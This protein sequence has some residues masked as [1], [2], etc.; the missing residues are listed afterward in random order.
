MKRRIT[1]RLLVFFLK[2][3]LAAGVLFWLVW[4]RRL[5]LAS[6]RVFL[7][8]A[9]P[10]VLAPTGALAVLLGQLL[11]AVRLRMLLK[12]QGLTVSYRR[13]AGLTLIGSLLGV[14]LPGLIG[15]DAVKSLYL[16]ADAPYSRS[17][18][19]AAVMIDRVIGLYSLLL[20]GSLTAGGVWIAGYLPLDSPA[21]WAAPLVTATATLV[22]VA[23]WFATVRRKQPPAEGAP[24]KSGKLLNLLEAL[25][26]SLKRPRILAAAV[27]LSLLN[28]LLVILTFLAAALLIG[29]DLPIGSH[30]LLAPPAMVLNAVPLTPGGLGI[31]EGGFS[32]LYETVG[33]SNGAEIGLLG[34]AIQYAAFAAGG[35]IAVLAVR[36]RRGLTAPQAASTGL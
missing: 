6:F 7:S 14:A 21:L 24:P 1:K 13:S 3:G 11:L 25:G 12:T 29:V 5:N 35:S 22:I 31:T 27:G 28:H 16:F 33:S 4:T 23:G 19:L 30:F 18:A 9:R 36:F 20:L 34:R 26:H 15:G 10:A 2:F 32:L 8:G 17:R